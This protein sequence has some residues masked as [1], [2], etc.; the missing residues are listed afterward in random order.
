MTSCSLFVVRDQGSAQRYPLRNGL[1][2]TTN[3]EQ[4][5]RRLHGR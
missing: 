5:S 1:P 3:N 2:R 4:R